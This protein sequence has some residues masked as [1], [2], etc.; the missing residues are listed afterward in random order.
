MWSGISRQLSN[1]SLDNDNDNNNDA[2]MD[3]GRSNNNYQGIQQATLS[4]TSLAS[5]S[6][7]RVNGYSCIPGTLGDEE[8]GNSLLY[9][10]HRWQRESPLVAYMADESQ[11]SMR[12][13]DS[14]PEMPRRD[15]GGGMIRSNSMD[16]ASRFLKPKDGQIGPRDGGKSFYLNMVAS[17]QLNAHSIDIDLYRPVG[18][19][20]NEIRRRQLLDTSPAIDLHKPLGLD[21]LGPRTRSYSFDMA[22]SLP[23]RSA[24]ESP[25]STY[26]NNSTMAANKNEI[27][28]VPAYD[29][30]IRAIH[31]ANE[32]HMKSNFVDHEIESFTETPDDDEDFSVCS[33]QESD[34]PSERGDV[35]SDFP[36]DDGE[37]DFMESLDEYPSRGQS[38]SLLA[39]VRHEGHYKYQKTY[40]SDS[41]SDLSD[42]DCR[43]ARVPRA[44]STTPVQ[45]IVSSLGA[46]KPDPDGLTKH[47]SPNRAPLDPTGTCTGPR[48]RRAL[49]SERIHS[50]VSQESGNQKWR[51]CLERS[52]AQRSSRSLS[53]VNGKSGSPP[54]V[55]I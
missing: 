44:V 25:Q 15:Q 47:L 30:T 19:N 1:S 23:A 4:S 32:R 40:D 52:M 38:L 10:N 54:P 55:A 6:R 9:Y 36:S 22:P 17:S 26:S 3:H 42:D 51:Q 2:C 33:S 53:N 21:A 11:R 8:E 13:F 50:S 5:E 45:T 14:C 34:M 48:P 7:F 39:N 46:R 28:P 20:I 24:P 37:L 12:S 49:S 29:R 27:P 43:I 31:I 41:E 16:M 35:E 18:L